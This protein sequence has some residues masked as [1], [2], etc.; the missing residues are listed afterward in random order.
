[1]IP[2]VDHGHEATRDTAMKLLDT[3][4]WPTQ[5]AAHFAVAPDI[6]AACSVPEIQTALPSLVDAPALNSGCATPTSSI[7]FVN[8]EHGDASLI[9]A[10][11]PG[12]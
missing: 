2:T 10:H 1:M 6:V 12:G 3:S 4:P 7:C 11:L 8:S 5:R 9:A